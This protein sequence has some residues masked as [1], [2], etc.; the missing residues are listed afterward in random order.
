MRLSA[1]VLNILVTGSLSV[2]SSQT[3]A[4]TDNNDTRKIE[5]QHDYAQRSYKAGFKS[6]RSSNLLE[7]IRLG[8]QL[9]K[10][11][12]PV[13]IPLEPS[14]L[15][16]SDTLPNNTATALNTTL[17][18]NKPAYKNDPK[19]IARINTIITTASKP[20]LP[21][22]GLLVADNS[23]NTT[24]L[25][26]QAPVLTAE[27]QEALKKQQ[28]EKQLAEQHRLE[29]ET[30]IYE[31]VNKQLIRYTQNKNTL[32]EIIER[33]RPYLYHIVSGLTQ[34]QLPSELA[35]LPIVESAYQPTAQSPK[36][37]AG[38][39]QFI[40]STGADFDL[41]QTEQYDDRLDI[42]ASTQAAMRYLSF[43]KRHF[44]GDWLLALAAYNCGLGAVDEAIKK[45]ITAGLSTDYWSLDLPLE[46]QDYVP[47]LLA[48]SIIFADPARFNLKFPIIRN[49][50]Y[51]IQVRIDKEMDMQYLANK[52]FSEIAEL[53]GLNYEQFN[54][55]NPGYLQV[56]LNS[57][58]PV[59]FLMPISNANTLQRHLNAVS[60]FVDAD[61]AIPKNAPSTIRASTEL[62]AY[63]AINSSHATK[64]ATVSSPFI[65]LNIN[66][67]KTTPRIK[68]QPLVNALL[69]TNNTLL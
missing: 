37:A 18:Q 62:A 31:R 28:A 21:E 49:E 56:G 22:V 13:A 39:W 43:L 53:A 45:N 17:S 60:K 23:N 24:A 63:T 47:R 3:L 10:P 14:A 59:T 27:Q 5:S 46:T 42:T 8:M 26:T 69:S 32:Y 66:A 29:R 15:T 67:N 7:R 9:P 57:T 50:P 41:K 65:S 58:E 44:K 1:L 12:P 16:I 68:Q 30:L 48:L 33:S 61:K 51:F 11:N 34:Y 6:K 54:R 55:L 52:S 36:S 4:R 40:P 2:Y 64:L 25:I 20:V 35:L 38:L 19:E